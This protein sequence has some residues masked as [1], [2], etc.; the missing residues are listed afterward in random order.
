MNELSI[1]G[2]WNVCGFHCLNCD[3]FKIDSF[4]LTDSI[5]CE[6]NFDELLMY[7][8]RIINSF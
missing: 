4:L 6:V 2:S 3:Y 8:R 7:V 5:L 1:R